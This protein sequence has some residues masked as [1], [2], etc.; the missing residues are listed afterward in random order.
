MPRLALA[1]RSVTAA[2]VNC[3]AGADSTSPYR[4][5][6]DPSG[7]VETFHVRP[8]TN[9]CTSTADAADLAVHGA[10]PRCRRCRSDNRQIGAATAGSSAP[11]P[12]SAPERPASTAGV[13]RVATRVVTPVSTIVRVASIEA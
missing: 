1:L 9:T 2:L 8:G 4:H 10:L 13:L 12:H 11:G 5:A 7:F 6:A 3:G